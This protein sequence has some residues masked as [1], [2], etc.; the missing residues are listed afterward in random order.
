MPPA[1][2]PGFASWLA[3]F[4]QLGSERQ[5]GYMVRGR[6]PHRAILQFTEGWPVW[7]ADLFYRVIRA[8]DYV[9]LAHGTDLIEGL[10]KEDR[11]V[12]DN[13]ARDAVRGSRRR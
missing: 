5:L 12:S 8:L 10:D 2:I 13:P 6:I 9:Y 4:E 3:D 1:V 7:E 11:P